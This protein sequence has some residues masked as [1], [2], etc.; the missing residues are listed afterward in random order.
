MTPNSVWKRVHRVTPRIIL[1]L[2]SS[3]VA[4]GSHPLTLKK[5]DGIVL[6]KPGKP[7]YD[8][9]SSF[10]V[11]VLLQTLSK[12][13]ERIINSRL[14]CMARVSGLVNPHQCG[15]LA[16]LSASDA[17]TT[18]THEVKTLQTAGK[19]VS[20]HFLHIKG[21]FDNVNPSTLSGMQKAKGVNPYLVAW[22]RSFLSGRTCPLLYQGSP[23]IFAPVSV[24]T[25]EA[26]PSPHY[27]SLSTCP[28]YTRKSPWGSPSPTLTTSD[29]R[30][31]HRPT[32]GTS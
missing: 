15:S 18:L 24:G 19:K 12:I 7:S 10:P 27:C 2:L 21:G 20:T 8:S 29:S 14:S 26:S 4:Y 23:M 16:G 9:P 5:A 25:P 6:D 28:A 30:H 31:L 11:I 13:L 3:L 17:T 32:G 22:T 1:D